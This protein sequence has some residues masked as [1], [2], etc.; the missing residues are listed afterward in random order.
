[1][2]KEQLQGQKT[3]KVF[4]GK[5]V[6][7]KINPLLDFSYDK[8]P[9]IFS[10]YQTKR[11]AVNTQPHL[12]QLQ[13]NLE[14]MKAMVNIGL[15]EPKL[16]AIGKGDKLDREDGIT[17]NDLFRD[18]ELGTRLYL[19]ILT[20]SLNRFTGLKGLFFSIRTRH[21]LLTLWRKNTDSDQL[22]SYFQKV[23]TQ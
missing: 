22:I 5:Y 17:V 15:V 3:I 18:M 12:S 1:M 19:E 16:V 4:G 13:K 8:I 10:I 9:Q 21:L 6:I 23:I 7:R 2:K 11:P 14:D 20:H